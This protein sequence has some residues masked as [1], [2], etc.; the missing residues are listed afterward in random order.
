MSEPAVGR[1]LSEPHRDRLPRNHPAYELIIRS[2]NDALRIGADSYPD[3]VTGLSVLTAGFLMA[4]GTCCDS[5]CRH[6]PY[7]E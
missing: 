7:A 3:P 2:H 5:G 4:R 1:P 6:C